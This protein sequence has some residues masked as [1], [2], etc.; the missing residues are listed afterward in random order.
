MSVNANVG[1]GRH[2]DELWRDAA[3]R[4]IA[5]RT[6]I[7]ERHVSPRPEALRNLLDHLGGALPDH[8]SDPR[9]SWPRSTDTAPPPH[10]TTA[11]VLQLRHRQFTTEAVPSW[12]A[13]TWD[14][15]TGLMAAPA[16]TLLEQVR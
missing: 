7:T 14:Q 12:L 13:T 8:P 2:L 5:Y 16:T 1:A 4:A 9:T 10:G 6:S 11:P 15:N 3:E